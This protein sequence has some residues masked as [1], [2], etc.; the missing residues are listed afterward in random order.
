[1]T[2]SNSITEEGL[3]ISKGNTDKLTID[4]LILMTSG[5]VFLAIALKLNKN[6]ATKV[7]INRIFQC[8]NQLPYVNVTY[9]FLIGIFRQSVYIFDKT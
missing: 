3:E 6:K 2:T 4:V 8:F 1:M 7:K 5:L 9:E